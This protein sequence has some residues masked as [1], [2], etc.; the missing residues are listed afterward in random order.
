MWAA[1]EEKGVLAKAK[2]A[3]AMSPQTAVIP[4]D[5]SQYDGIYGLASPTIMRFMFNKTKSALDIETLVG[6]AFVPGH[7][8][9]GREFL[10]KDGRFYAG[11]ISFSFAVAQDGRELFQQHDHTNGG[12]STVGESI[13]QDKS[14][15]TSQFNN[16]TWVPRNLSA[17]DFINFT[18]KGLYKTGTIKALPG[19]IY[20]YSGAPLVSPTPGVASVAYGLSDKYTSKMILP[21]LPDQ[22]DIKLIHEDGTKML[23]AGAFEFTDA[24]TVPFLQ[25]GE[26]III[27]RDGNDVSRKV[28]SATSF[29]STIPADGRILIYSPDG[30]QIFDSLVM[31]NQKGSI[32]VFI[33]DP[34]AVFAITS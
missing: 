24:E 10:Y 28:T 27:G 19:I 3:P 25:K 23:K 5:L 21:Y 11:D 9:P 30:T 13:S 34:N 18:Y 31:S 4:K 14:I 20:L 33:G 15:D 7:V 26:K 12:A 17:D 8:L 2:T 32:I 1:L 29:T 6:G 16:M 22:V